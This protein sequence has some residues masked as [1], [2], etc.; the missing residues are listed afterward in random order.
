[1]LHKFNFGWQRFSG[2]GGVAVLWLSIGIAMSIAHLGLIDMRPISY[3]GVDPRTKLLFSGGLL[4]SSALFIVFALQLH[5][6]FKLRPRFLAYFLVGQAGQ[7]VAA[8]VPYGA[9]SSLRLIHTIAAYI[10]AFSLPLL[11]REFAR[12]RSTDHFYPVYRWLTWLELLAFAVGISLFVFTSGIAP[13]GEALPALGFH[14]W[15]IVIT[16]LLKYRSCQ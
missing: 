10:L 16:F 1:M 9:T 11:I 8:I 13:L 2:L 7:I 3:L 14:L 12:S 4:L 15:I 6:N 5:R